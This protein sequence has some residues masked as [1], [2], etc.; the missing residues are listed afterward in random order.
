MNVPVPTPIY[1]F[2]HVDNLYVCLRREALHAPNHTPNDGLVYKTIHNVDIQ[3]RRSITGILRGPRG[4]IHDY[5]SFYFGPRSPML[6][7]LHTG[8][9]I[10]YTEEQEPLIYCVSTAQD[11]QRVG[12]GFVFSDGQGIANFTSWFDNLEDLNKVDWDAVYA[13]IW[14]DTIDDMDRQRRKQAEF[15]VHQRCDWT[16]INEIGV[17]NQAMKSRVEHILAEFAESLRRPVR[18][19]REWYY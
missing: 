10:D 2:L 11:I 13:K 19:K 3:R 9:N 18:I 5:V 6:Y 14:K 7:Q 17:V 4:T 15:L 1:R 8:Y 12:I 16:L